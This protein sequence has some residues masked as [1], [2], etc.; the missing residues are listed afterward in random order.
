MNPIPHPSRE[1]GKLAQR[2][3]GKGR[4]ADFATS[5][6]QKESLTEGSLQEEGIGGGKVDGGGLECPGLPGAGVK[7]AVCEL[8]HLLGDLLVASAGLFYADRSWHGRGNAR[9]FLV[10]LGANNLK[11]CG[12]VLA[13]LLNRAAAQFMPIFLGSAAHERLA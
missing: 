12:S 3:R 8:E 6:I 2:V 7:L 5:K 1:C 9:N 13:I 10:R 4:G 11:S